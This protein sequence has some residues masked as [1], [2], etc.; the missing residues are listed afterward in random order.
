MCLLSGL[1]NNTCVPG[2]ASGVAKR[3]NAPGFSCQPMAKVYNVTNR[4]AKNMILLDT[5][6]S[7][8]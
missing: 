5:A 1:K 7:I 2:V 4:L 3:L 6:F 8:Q